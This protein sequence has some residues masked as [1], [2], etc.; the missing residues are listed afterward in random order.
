[1]LLQLE[2][3][4]LPS[5]GRCVHLT[6]SFC[7]WMGFRLRSVGIVV[8]ERDRAGSTSRYQG[9]W[10]G[11]SLCGHQSS[12]GVWSP[13]LGEP[14][15]GLW[16]SPGCHIQ[17][18]HGGL[19]RGKTSSCL[20]I[21]ELPFLRAVQGSLSLRPGAVPVPLS[22]SWGCGKRFLVLCTDPLAIL[23]PLWSS[24]RLFRS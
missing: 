16:S 22:P 4:Y 3:N 15:P 23:T 9:P 2:L 11:M 1:M 13:H 14:W 8:W 10:E 17:A 19:G 7:L 18:P 5:S 24:A 12:G 20:C 6:R 21:L